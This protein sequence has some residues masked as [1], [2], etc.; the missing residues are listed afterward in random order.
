MIKKKIFQNCIVSLHFSEKKP[1]KCEKKRFKELMKKNPPP[2]I[3]ECDKSGKKFASKQCYDGKD[4]TCMVA[5]SNC[6]GVMQTD[7][8]P[9]NDST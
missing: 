5:Q 7:N 3:L 2:H 4:L 8:L 1:G 9:K 6:I